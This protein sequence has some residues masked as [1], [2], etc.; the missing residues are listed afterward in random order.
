MRDEPSPASQ[1]PLASQASQ[2][3]TVEQG[4]GGGGGAWHIAAVVALTGGVLAASLLI[5][6]ERLRPNRKGVPDLMRRGFAREEGDPEPRER[7]GSSLDDAMT[8]YSLVRTNDAESRVIAEERTSSLNPPA[9]AEATISYDRLGQ[10]IAN[11]LRAAENEATQLLAAARAEAQAIRDEAEKETQDA[12]AGFEGEMAA[13][14]EETTRLRNDAERFADEKRREADREAGQIRTEAQAQARQHLQEGKAAKQR[15]EAEG[16][17][18]QQELAEASRLVEERLPG[19]LTA[20][21]E[22]VGQLEELVGERPAQL[23]ETL[24][25][26]SARAR[27]ETELENAQ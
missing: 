2:P 21:R 27:R 25:P 19:A 14:R 13:R 8:A 20:C 10:S 26:G 7:G 24:A 15:L 23:H 4:G 12:R 18:R 17:M 22:V 3:S 5:F 6:R 11:M 1:R 9:A 16:R